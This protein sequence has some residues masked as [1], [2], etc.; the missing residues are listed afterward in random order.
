MNTGSEPEPKPEPRPE[1]EPEPGPSPEP[2]GDNTKINTGAPEEETPATDLTKVNKRLRVALI[3]TSTLVALILVAVIGSVVYLNNYT[4]NFTVNLKERLYGYTAWNDEL[5]VKLGDIIEYKLEF[6]NDSSPLSS[7]LLNLCDKLGIS[8]TSRKVKVQ[9]TL[10]DNLEYVE[11]STAL[12]DSDVPDGAS[13]IMNDLINSPDRPSTVIDTITTSGIDI[14]P[15]FIN[16]N[17]SICIRCKIVKGDLVI[18]FDEDRNVDV[19]SGIERVVTRATATV[20]DTVE[21]DS[22]TL[23]L[24]Y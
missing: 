6:V 8:V 7:A 16:A 23:F 22:A 21:E 24:R 11:G 1:P 9:F 17:G 10:P 15:S 14:N 4:I 12:Y 18:G 13:T 5:N 20:D 19:I 3:T 2:D